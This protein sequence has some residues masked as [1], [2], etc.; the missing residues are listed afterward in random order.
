[1]GPL[2]EL[3]E[4]DLISLNIIILLV[5]TKDDVPDFRAAAAISNVI[6]QIIP[7]IYCDIETFLIEG[8]ILE[9]KLKNIR[10]SSS[11]PSYIGRRS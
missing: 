4:A 2:L 6:T 10:D 11:K 1:V 3:N 9:S 7:G 5:K 8:K